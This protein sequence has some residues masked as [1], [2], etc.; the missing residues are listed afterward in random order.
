MGLGMAGWIS[1]HVA[2]IRV[3][4]QNDSGPKT[5]KQEGCAKSKLE[6]QKE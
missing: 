4:K 5:T 6:L 2:E 1:R 3:G